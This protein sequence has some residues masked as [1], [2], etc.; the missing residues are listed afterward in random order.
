MIV[1]H[2]S[3][4]RCQGSLIALSEANLRDI[5]A[6][7]WH[8]S[9]EV[10][11][12]C[13]IAQ[14]RLSVLILWP[15]LIKSLEHPCRIRSFRH[16]C[17]LVLM[18]LDVITCAGRK[19]SIL[20]EIASTIFYNNVILFVYIVKP[21][22]SSFIRQLSLFWALH[23]HESILAHV[24]ELLHA[25]LQVRKHECFTGSIVICN[26]QLLNC[27]FLLILGLTAGTYGCHC[28]PL[29]RRAP[30]LIFLTARF[31]TKTT[32]VLLFYYFLRALSCSKCI[33]FV[34]SLL[35]IML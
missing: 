18:L 9:M 28:V 23:T 13:A 5:H 29:S 31:S 20:R 22:L 3:G 27:L 10:R 7:D 6:L 24:L 14:K 2:I 34:L 19:W 33:R 25:G 16:S 11:N 30:T 32:P 8:L 26:M 35:I 17:K 15:L 21:I 12:I 1:A 4:I